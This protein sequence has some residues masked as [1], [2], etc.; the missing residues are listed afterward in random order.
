[1]INNVILVGRITKDPEVRTISSGAATCS[2]TLA[3][4]RNFSSNQGERQ[5]DFIPCVAW[6]QSATFLG[7]YVK[8]GYLLGIEGR[9]QTRQYQDQQNQ[10]RYVTEVVVSRLE[11]L[12]PKGA[13]TSTSNYQANNNYQD[14][15]QPVADKSYNEEISDDDLPF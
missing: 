7:N 5:A 3:V 14:N 12:T 6:N 4:D 10:T 15:S 1:M 2:F 8:K 13:Q 11:N 9:I